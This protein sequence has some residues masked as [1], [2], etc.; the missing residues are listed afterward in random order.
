MSK[1]IIKSK[2]AVTKNQGETDL[3][4]HLTEVVRLRS[5]QITIFRR[6]LSPLVKLC[7]FIVVVYFIIHTNIIGTFSANK[8]SNIGHTET[9]S[10]AINKESASDPSQNHYLEVIQELQEINAEMAHKLIV[11]NRKISDLEKENL[12]MSLKKE[13]LLR[14]N[15]KLSIILN[16]APAQQ[17]QLS[18]S[19][20]LPRILE[21]NFSNLTL[22]RNIQRRELNQLKNQHQLQ[23]TTL[24]RYLNQSGDIAT[25]KITDLR[26]R[27]ELEVDVLRAHHQQVIEDFRGQKFLD[28]QQI[29]YQA[30]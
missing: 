26:Q 12:E 10:V 1:Q 11:K 9:P 28:L 20:S 29:S 5:G 6:E 25:E 16:E 24:T 22:L 27:H 13:R 17:L 4:E 18:S 23:M 30:R 19:N 15:Q 2:S 14:D 21:Y 7:I 8:T 3:K